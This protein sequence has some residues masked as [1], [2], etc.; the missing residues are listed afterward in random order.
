MKIESYL[1]AKYAYLGLIQG[2][3][4][5]LASTSAAF[6]GFAIA[7]AA[8]ILAIESAISASFHIPLL[9]IAFIGIATIG[10]F[11]CWY[12]LMEKRYRSLYDSVRKDE[13]AVDFDMSHPMKDKISPW[14]A[15]KSPSIW[16][17]YLAI[18]IAFIGISAIVILN[19][20]SSVT[21]GPAQ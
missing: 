20:F 11:D 17:F 9:A 1:S 6:K 2:V 16:L 15:L 21:N 18:I 5:R 12:F 7:L 19:D 3:I 8:G 13:H 14:Q 10:C 4:N